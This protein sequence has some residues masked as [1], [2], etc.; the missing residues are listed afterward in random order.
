MKLGPFST[1]E[2][3]QITALGTE[4]AVAEIL[5]TGVGFLIDKKWGTGPW[6]LVLGAIIGFVVGMY[7]IICAAG[8]MKEDEK[9]KR[10]K[11][12]RR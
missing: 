3:V 8:N 5:S 7:L 10:T 1:R 9:L 4:F 12:G 6:F 2:H 11:D